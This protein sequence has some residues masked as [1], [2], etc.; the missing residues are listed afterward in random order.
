MV[1]L[2]IQTTKQ[3]NF[4]NGNNEFYIKVKDL[5]TNLQKKGYPITPKSKLYIRVKYFEDYILIKN[6]NEFI[7]MSMLS[8][9]NEIYLKIKNYFE[10]SLI[11]DTFTILKNHFLQYP[12]ENGNYKLPKRKIKDIVKLVYRYHILSYGYLNEQKKYVKYSL[13][14][15]AEII[16][17]PK[18][19]LDNYHDQVTKARKTNFDFNKHQDEDYSFLCRYNR[20]NYNQ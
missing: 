12:Q 4:K 8:P 1:T 11:D 18:S 14:K 9:K 17:V 6:E 7:Y 20:Q 10:K 5:I 19:T 16:G 3:T 15:A 13:E 2:P